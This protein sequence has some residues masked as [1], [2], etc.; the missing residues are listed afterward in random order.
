MSRRQRSRG[1]TSPVRKPL[2]AIANRLKLRDKN[3]VSFDGCLD[4]NV[5]R[6]S[7]AKGKKKKTDRF[8]LSFFLS[9]AS[10][11]RDNA[12]LATLLRCKLQRK[13]RYLI[14]YCEEKGYYLSSNTNQRGFS[15]G[16]SDSRCQHTKH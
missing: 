6:R 3:V 15:H 9:L 5:V 8:S 4:R 2:S 13:A 7:K 16:K 14:A 1:C 11:A 10:I 12:A